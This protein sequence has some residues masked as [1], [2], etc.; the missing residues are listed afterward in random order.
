MIDEVNNLPTKIAESEIE[1]R[2]DF[3]EMC[4]FTLDPADAKDL[5][6]ALFSN[7]RKWKL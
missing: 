6:D 1:K 5:D 7:T 4:T 2:R 3:R